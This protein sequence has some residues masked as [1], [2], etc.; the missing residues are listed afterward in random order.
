MPDTSQPASR[1][2]ERNSPSPQPISRSFPLTLP[3]RHI[4]PSAALSFHVG[5]QRRSGAAI[6]DHMPGLRFWYPETVENSPRLRSLPRFA[7][8]F[9]DS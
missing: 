8:H 9:A 6:L 1:M 3:L 2:R 5:K 7:D 4:V